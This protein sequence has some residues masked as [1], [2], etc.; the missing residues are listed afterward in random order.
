MYYKIISQGQ[1][2]DAA[3]DDQLNYVRW[4]DKNGMF[5]SCTPE[6]ADGIVSTDGDEIYLLEGPSAGAVLP[7]AP[8][9]TMA[10]ITEEEYLEIREEMD[11]GQ[12]IV[13]PDGE[14]QEDSQA[15]TRLRQ[16][17]EMVAS[18]QSMKAKDNYPQGSYFVLHDEVYR[19]TDPISKGSEIRP[20]YNCEKKSLDEF[21]NQEGE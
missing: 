9:I 4:Q 16:L 2:I 20:G 17:E 13:N 10:E 14:Q 7:D 12:A 21:L 1:I 18:L 5:L 19:A 6:L 3:P 11:A 15:K 8:V